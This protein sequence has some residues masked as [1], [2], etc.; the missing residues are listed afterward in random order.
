METIKINSVKEY[1]QLV[2]KYKGN[3]LFRGQAVSD[4][5]IVP[6]IYRGDIKLDKVANE[7]KKLGLFKSDDILKKVLELQHWGE[8]TRLCDLTI[9][10]TVALYFV[11]EDKSQVD[12]DGAVFIIDRRNAYSYDSNQVKILMRLARGDLQ[13]FREAKKAIATDL[14]LYMAD[15]EFRKILTGNTI[16]EYDR[17]IAYSNSRAIVQGGTGI[18]FGYGLDDND[19]LLVKG[20]VDVRGIIKKIIIPHK[21]KAHIIRHLKTIG[22]YGD[23]LYGRANEI[24]NPNLSYKIEEMENRNKSFGQKIILGLYVS[25]LSYTD[26]DIQRVIAEAY[27]D[28]KQRYGKSARVWINVYYDEEDRRITNCNYIARAIP[29]SDYIDYRVEINHGYR[30]SRMKNLNVEV[31]ILEIMRLTEPIVIECKKFLKEIE[32]FHSM[33]VSQ[34]ATKD[35]YYDLLKKAYIKRQKMIYEDMDNI[36]RGSCQ[37]DMYYCG[38]NNFCK[39][40]YELAWEVCNDI[41]KGENDKMLEWRYVKWLEKCM[42]NYQIYYSTA[43][44]LSI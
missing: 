25:D 13:D 15:N 28:Y 36:E 4:W 24:E 11:I 26:E 18:Y 12:E 35:T 5:D 20:N 41:K 30:T 29:N 40:V 32:E 31:S 14:S 16:I 42:N 10:P 3:M 44:S 34:N 39:S 22:I 9:N 43:L 6:G 1:Y 33:Y 38:S 21:L 19:N 37:Y 2:E 17:E 7:C 23:L 27:Q 8:K